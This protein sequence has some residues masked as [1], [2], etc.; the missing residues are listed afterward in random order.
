MTQATRLPLLLT[1]LLPLV[2]AARVSNLRVPVANI[3]V[4]ASPL[5]RLRAARGN[6]HR[7]HANSRWHKELQFQLILLMALQKAVAKG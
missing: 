1:V 3:R 4:D 2:Q 7:P 5:C 6:D